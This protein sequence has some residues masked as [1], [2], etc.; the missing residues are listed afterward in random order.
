MADKE[1][2]EKSEFMVHID[3]PSV[4]YSV[5]VNQENYV[6]EFKHLRFFIKSN[7]DKLH[8]L[9]S[10]ILEIH[11]KTES[12]SVLRKPIQCRFPKWFR[13]DNV[14]TSDAIALIL[15]FVGKPL[16]T[17]QVSNVMNTQFKRIDLRNVSKHLTSK[18]SD[19]Y[20]YTLY[21]DDTS[22]YELSNLGKNWV[23]TEL[24]DTIKKRI[25]DKAKSD[26]KRNTHG[27]VKN[28]SLVA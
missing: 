27:R 26:K 7:G 12:K 21:D 14:E 19:L 5:A 1:L 15:Y 2:R 9:A 13:P 18:T 25:Q 4:T 17:G 10:E 8:E 11:R 28:E 6:D 22:T 16:T 20:G 24:L 23:E 3:T